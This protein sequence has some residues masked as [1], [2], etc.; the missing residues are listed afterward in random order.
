MNYMFIQLVYTSINFEVHESEGVNLVIRILKLAGIT[1]KD[2]A[3][4][5]LSTQEEVKDIQQ[6]KQ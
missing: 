3:L 5:Q 2:P 4:V 6:K 1:L